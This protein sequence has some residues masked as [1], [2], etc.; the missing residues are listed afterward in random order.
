M[1]LDSGKKIVPCAL[2]GNFKLFRSSVKIVY[3]KAIDV[4]GMDVDDA[5]N[6]LRDKVLELLEV[7]KNMNDNY[8]DILNISAE[9]ISK[10]V[11]RLVL[12]TVYFMEEDDHE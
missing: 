4:S 12:D 9:D 8:Q 2:S 10:F 1:A 7:D 11:E 6:L 5:N 3:G